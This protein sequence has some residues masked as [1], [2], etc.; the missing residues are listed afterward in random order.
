MAQTLEYN[1]EVTAVVPVA[2]PTF[3]DDLGIIQKLD[4]EPNDVGGLTAAELKAK[5]DEGNLTAQQYINNVLIPKVVADDLTEQT[6]QA[7]E[8]ERVANEIER[9]S[10]ETNRVNAENSRATAE[11]T[12]VNAEQGRVSA[13]NARVAAEQARVDVNNGIVAQATEQANAAKRGADNAEAFK[14]SAES[15]AT[16]AA[17]SA[18]AASTSATSAAGSA[19]A[20]ATSANNAAGS[21]TAAANAAN[22]ATN[23]VKANLQQ[24]VTDAE[25]AESGAKAAQAAAEKARDEAQGI[26]GG[27]Y[28]T[29]DEAQGYA[30]TA[31]S[32]ANTYTDEQIAAIPAPDV[33]GQIAAHN[34]DTAAHPDIRTAVSNA[35]STATAA[36]TAANSKM[37]TDFS[38]ASAVLSAAKGGTGVTSLEA[39][40][41]A[42]G[43]GGGAKIA[44]GSYV[45]TNLGGAANAITLTFDFEPRLLWVYRFRQASYS[46]PQLFIITKYDASDKIS[47][48]YYAEWNTSSDAFKETALISSTFSGNTVSW[49]A[50]SGSAM[51]NTSNVTYYYF[52]IG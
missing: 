47:G 3:D 32:N 15:S 52:A 2:I 34:A 46:Y 7:A 37:A 13:E 48:Y 10:N 33:S 45:G 29:K 8:S 39:L 27:D 42:L 30:D 31:E 1:K 4:D 12:R 16:S 44:F 38:N 50:N 41:E 43:V 14:V 51:M 17:G 18:S 22:K 11:Q 26:V 20:A 23:D 5:F 6:R 9:V 19:S 40:A 49:Y 28:A 25:N 35:Q 36:Q 21:A 24:L